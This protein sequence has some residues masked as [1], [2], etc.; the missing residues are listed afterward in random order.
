MPS[1]ITHQLVA[2][3]AEKLLPEG[4][5]HI[6]ERAPDEYFLGCQ[7][8]DLFF[9]YRI[10][11]KSEYNL[12]KFL[13]RNRPY[14]VFRFFARLLSGEQSARFP[15]YSDED[16][17]RAFAYILG[18]IAHY[19]TDSTF[20]PFVYNYMDKEGSEKRVHQLIENDWD[21]YFLRKFRGRE[22]E[23]FRCAFSPK[24]VAKSGA[25]ARLYACLAEEL[26]REEVKRGR[27]NAGLRNFW[28]YLTFFHG[29]CY[30][31]QH[32]W[33]RCERFF[34]AKPFLSCLYPRRQPD[35]DY[36]ANDDFA[37]LSEEKGKSADELFDRAR[38]ES[39]RLAI[40]FCECVRKGEPL[41]REE[42]CLSF[43]TAQPVEDEK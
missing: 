26:G 15:A 39:A 1:A 43:L 33:E 38:D 32:G 27:F 9:F 10:G 42:F 11:N 3:E 5:Q 20:H 41:P 13:H 36:L 18:Y 29:K 8:P 40:L 6:I 25:V 17:T 30:S 12:G 22:A 21:V 16:R 23:K 34:R 14:D 31:S 28:R 35:P 4:L 37:R 24:K 19:A 7:G 2:E